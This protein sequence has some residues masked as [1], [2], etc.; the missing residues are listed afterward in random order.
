MTEEE[1]RQIRQR[2]ERALEGPWQVR[3]SKPRGTIVM[4]VQ[5]HTRPMVIASRADF[6]S[7]GCEA[8]TDE[9]G[10][11]V[12][13]ARAGL[14]PQLLATAEFIAHSRQDVEALLAEIDTL[15]KALSEVRGQRAEE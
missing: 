9:E 5:K 14:S 15:R 6:Y 11:F 8:P 13:D 4:Q 2:C 3:F 7:E 10:Y 12:A 1:L